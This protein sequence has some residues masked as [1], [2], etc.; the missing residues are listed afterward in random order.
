MEV[1]PPMLGHAFGGKH[2]CD[3]FL[4]KPILEFLQIKFRDRCVGSLDI[5]IVEFI[6]FLALATKLDSGPLPVSQEIDDIWHAYI[7]ETGEYA[8]LCQKLGHFIHHTAMNHPTDLD[9]NKQLSTDIIFIVGYVFNF[10]ALSETVLHLW[11]AATRLMSYLSLTL[12]QLNMFALELC[13]H[14]SPLIVPPLILQNC[15][16]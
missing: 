6:K 16:K 2:L 1:G 3:T 9:I 5:M 8:L 14:A 12:P 13:E 10:G 4:S 7:L 11:P 15:Y